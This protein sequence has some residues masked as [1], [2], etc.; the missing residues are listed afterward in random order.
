MVLKNKRNIYQKAS[1]TGEKWELGRHRHWVELVQEPAIAIERRRRRRR[2]GKFRV[3]VCRW[4][5]ERGRWREQGQSVRRGWG[6][7]HCSADRC[8]THPSRT[9]WAALLCSLASSQLQ[10]LNTFM[11]LIEDFFALRSTRP[12]APKL[13]SIPHHCPFSFLFL[14]FAAEPHSQ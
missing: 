10:S 2:R 1:V 3:G 12:N 6:R 13:F 5:R 14:T 9:C 7:M 4:G 11:T 8:E